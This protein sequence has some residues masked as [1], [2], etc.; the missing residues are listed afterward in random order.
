MANASCRGIWRVSHLVL[1]IAADIDGFYVA[2]VSVCFHELT[3]SSGSVIL[4]PSKPRAAYI[5]CKFKA[6][7]HMY[8][9]RIETIG[10]EI[11][12]SRL[13]EL[14]LLKHWWRALENNRFLFLGSL[15]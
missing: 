6:R 3:H 14:S 5:L 9:T 4:R 11:P 12:K 1:G 13:G 15:D 8:L 7:A 10:E 2:R